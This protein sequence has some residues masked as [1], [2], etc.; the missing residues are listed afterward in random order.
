MYIWLICQSRIVD[1]APREDNIQWHLETW[2]RLSDIRSWH[3]GKLVWRFVYVWPFLGNR[4]C[5]F[6]IKMYFMYSVSFLYIAILGFMHCVP[7][8]PTIFLYFY[9]KKDNKVER[10]KITKKM[11]KLVPDCLA[12]SLYSASSTC[13]FK[14]ILNID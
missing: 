9:F 13:T 14:K 2:F 11:A 6:Q 4:C 8:L 7:R 1:V 5:H 10:Q 3:I 12:C